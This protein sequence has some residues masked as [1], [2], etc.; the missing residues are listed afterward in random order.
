MRPQVAAEAVL[1]GAG[2]F[3]ARE[4]EDQISSGEKARRVAGE[5]GLVD[6]ILGE[7]RLAEPVRGDDD[8]VLALGEEVEGLPT[9]GAARGGTP[10]R[11]TCMPLSQRRSCADGGSLASS[12]N[13]GAFRALCEPP[14][15]ERHVRWCGR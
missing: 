5:D 8:D 12:M 3:L 10:A 9:T 1:E 15:A 2:G 14:D 13:S 11:V 4:V 7:H 6:Q